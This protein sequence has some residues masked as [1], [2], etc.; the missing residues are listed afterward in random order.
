[1]TPALSQDGRR[2]AYTAR[3]CDSTGHCT[4]DLVVQDMAGAGK[5]TILRG[6]NNVWWIWW[7][8]DAR[9][10]VLMASFGSD[11]WG[12]L[13][14]PSLGGEPLFL[15]CC[16]ATTVGASLLTGTR[17]SPPT[18][19]RWRGRAASSWAPLHCCSPSSGAPPRGASPSATVLTLALWPSRP[20]ASVVRLVHACMHDCGHGLVSSARERA[21]RPGRL[22][23]AGCP[24]PRAR[25]PQLGG[26]STPSTT[27]RAAAWTSRG[28]GGIETL[29]GRGRT[30]PSLG[31]KPVH[32]LPSTATRR[33]PARAGPGL[34]GRPQARSAPRSQGLGRRGARSSGFS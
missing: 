5:A 29:D 21:E 7:T 16:A 22:A 18:A 17:C 12:V 14:V 34:A 28:Y 30:A 13:S 19:S 23:C 3:Q 31:S 27:P 15:G 8:A 11:R 2:L 26:G 1:M 9:Y 4:V 25:T 32:V 20:P 6:L 10:L 33:R 24:D